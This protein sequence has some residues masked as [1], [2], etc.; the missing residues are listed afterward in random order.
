LL[1][2]SKE[3]VDLSIKS[4]KCP[5]CNSD[6]LKFIETE[7]QLR[8]HVLTVHGRT[9]NSGR[10]ATPQPTTDY[11]GANLMAVAMAEST[12]CAGCGNPFEGQQKC[13]HCGG[14]N[15]TIEDILKDRR[16]ERQ[17]ADPG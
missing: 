14:S 12:R 3:V 17:S 5:F 13:S 10:I 15:W 9:M 4:F 16:K 7:E 2:N 11:V 1:L 6:F 8:A